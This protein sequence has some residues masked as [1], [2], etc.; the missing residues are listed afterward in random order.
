MMVYGPVVAYMKESAFFRVAAKKAGKPGDEASPVAP[1]RL[2]GWVCL[3]LYYHWYESYKHLPVN[4][5]SSLYK[6][7]AA[8]AFHFVCLANL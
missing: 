8:P 3:V 4:P 6:K 2:T 7:L 5:V 1:G